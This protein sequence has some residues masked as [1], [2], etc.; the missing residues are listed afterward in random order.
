MIDIG[1]EIQQQMLNESKKSQHIFNN[2]SLTFKQ[3]KDIFTDVFDSYIVKVSRK[4]PISSIYVTNKDGEFYVASVD[5]P[6]KLLKVD[7]MK[8][9]IKLNEC[10][11]QSTNTT[12]NDVIDTLQTIDPILL[13]RY[14]AN[15]KNMLKCSLICP[16]GGYEDYYDDRC[17]ISFDGID[18][19]DGDYNCVGQDKKTGFELLNIL[20]SNDKLTNKFAS[21]NSEQLNMLRK[22]RAENKILSKIIEQLTKLV[23]GIG[24]G[25]SLKYYI[26]DKY[27][28]SIVNKA[29]EH[30][31]DVSKNGS[32]V[33]ELVSRLSG[34]SF[35]RPTKSDLMTFAKRE[36]IDCKSQEYKDFLNDIESTAKQTN[37]EVM[38]PIENMMYYA[39]SN[40]VN[41]IVAMIALDPNPKAKKLL[42]QIALDL[43][44]VC[45]EIDECEFDIEQIIDLKKTL[46]KI[47][48]YKD[49]A[50]TEIRIMNGHKP[51]SITG[52][53]DKLQKLCEVVE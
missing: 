6:E 50:P 38:A 30:G 17:F 45:D 7:A 23:D 41:N 29:L 9:A 8:N 52:Y 34:T 32:F 37:K 46:Q 47:C 2:D 48:Q 10:D 53:I 16:P 13:N 28:R 35:T 31:L 33:N 15:G 19:F 11:C 14:F 22:C 5:K 39:L 36:G 43:F 12:I 40:A 26:Q 42:N 49:I 3:L 24:W 20:I 1:Q 51:Y 21:L 44:N 27:S 25:C 18:C 4:V